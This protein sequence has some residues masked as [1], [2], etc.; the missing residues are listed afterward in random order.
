[1][2]ITGGCHAHK[3]SLENLTDDKLVMLNI[4]A[5][6]S[7]TV[8]GYYEKVQNI[9]SLYLFYKDRLGKYSIILHSLFPI[10]FGKNYMLFRH[11]NL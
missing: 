7:Y 3:K 10:K 6:N 9:F 4:S 11:E 1:M 5:W 8:Y 2:P